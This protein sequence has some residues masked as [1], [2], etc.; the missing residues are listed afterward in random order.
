MKKKFTILYFVGSIFIFSSHLSYSLDDQSKE[1]INQSLNQ[2]SVISIKKTGNKNKPFTIY[3]ENEI[4]VNSGPTLEEVFRNAE[5][6]TDPT[7]FL[8]R[9]QRSTPSDNERFTIPDSLFAPRV[10]E[11]QD[12]TQSV[13]KALDA[14]ELTSSLKVGTKLSIKLEGENIIILVDGGVT[15]RSSSLMGALKILSNNRDFF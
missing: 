1:F 2:G 6:D 3:I 9:M 7:N 15:A 13:I 5:P 10:S 4:P 8:N 14:A 12:L 11:N